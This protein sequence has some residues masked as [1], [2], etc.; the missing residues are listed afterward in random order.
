MYGYGDPG[1]LF[2]IQVDT[3]SIEHISHFWAYPRQI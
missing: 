2:V 1:P 3:Y